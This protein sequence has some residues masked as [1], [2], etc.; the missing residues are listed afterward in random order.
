MKW[1]EGATQGLVVAGGNGS[2]SA[3]NQF[4][5]ARDVTVDSSGNIYIAHHIRK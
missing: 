3:L 1:A 4:N 5:S 2:G